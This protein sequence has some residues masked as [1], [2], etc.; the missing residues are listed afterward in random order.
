MLSSRHISAQLD[1]PLLLSYTKVSNQS[2]SSAAKTLAS[3]R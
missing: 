2:M 1:N 3:V